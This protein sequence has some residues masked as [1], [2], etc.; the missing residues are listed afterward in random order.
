MVWERQGWGKR[1]PGGSLGPEG[2]AAA[3]FAHGLHHQRETA[4]L[5]LEALDVAAHGLNARR[6]GADLRMANAISSPAQKG[7]DQLGGLP[8]V[9]TGPAQLLAKAGKIGG[10]KGVGHGL[11]KVVLDAAGPRR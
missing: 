7:T 4:E 1:R 11:Q 2:V 5:L 8:R 3:H 6:G 9:K 10:G